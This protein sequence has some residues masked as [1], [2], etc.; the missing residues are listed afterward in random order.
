MRQSVEFVA[1]RDDF[2]SR[3]KAQNSQK[4]ISWFVVPFPGYSL[5][6]L[7]LR[8]CARG[9]LL[10]VRIGYGCDDFGGAAVSQPP[11]KQSARRC[12]RLGK[13]PSFGCGTSRA[14]FNDGHVSV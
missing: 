13:R 6:P 9:I 1:R 4:G 7:W 12:W 2:N 10:S 11:E 8:P 5:L 3:K 14:R